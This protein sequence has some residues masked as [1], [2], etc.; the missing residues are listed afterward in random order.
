[1]SSSLNGASRIDRGV[2]STGLSTDAGFRRVNLA[3]VVVI[4]AAGTTGR[5]ED[6]FRANGALER[7][8]ARL[9]S[10]AFSGVGCRAGEASISES[11]V[12]ISERHF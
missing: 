10:H 1:M 11:A 9:A 7:L 8:T 12:R 4:P 5:D 6:R 2:G 3:C